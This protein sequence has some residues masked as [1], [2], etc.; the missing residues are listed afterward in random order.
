MFLWKAHHCQTIIWIQ[1]RKSSIQFNYLKF[2]N[3]DLL[4]WF[5]FSLSLKIHKNSKLLWIYIYSTP[6][7]WDT[8]NISS[9]FKWRTAVWIQFFSSPRLTVIPRLKSTVYFMSIHIKEKKRWFHI[10]PE[11]I[12]M[13][14]N[15]NSFIRDLNLNHWIHFFNDKNQLCAPPK[16][17]EANLKVKDI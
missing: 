1:T 16:L 8:C 2:K 3:K 9:I 5:Y 6:L 17:L 11:G 12:S 15:F 13:K 7:P 4:I 10:F 14:W